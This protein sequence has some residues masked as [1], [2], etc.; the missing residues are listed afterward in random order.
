MIKYLTKVDNHHILYVNDKSVKVE[1]VG[2]RQYGETV[3]PVH[4]KYKK[5]TVNND[6][7]VDTN[8]AQLAQILL[9]I[10]LVKEIKHITSLNPINERG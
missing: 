9:A 2:E 7:S 5:I 10:E 1:E 3:Y 8:K 6:F 4:F